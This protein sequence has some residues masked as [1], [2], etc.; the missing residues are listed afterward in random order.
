MQP[1]QHHVNQPAKLAHASI[2]QGAGLLILLTLPCA[3]LLFGWQWDPAH[4]NPTLLHFFYWAS[5]TA[6]AYTA[7]LFCAILIWHL[8]LSPRKSLYLIAIL[9]IITALGLGLKSAL[10]DTLREPRPYV[11]WLEKNNF[12]APDQFYQLPHKSLFVSQQDLSQTAVP[13]WQ[14]QYWSK[15]TAYSF[16][17]G[18]SFFAAQW[19]LIMIALLWR[20]KAY[21]TMTLAMLWALAVLASRLYLGMHWPQDLILSC[22]MAFAL[23]WVGNIFWNKWVIAG[24]SSA[25]PN[26]PAQPADNLINS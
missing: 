4:T 17:S 3:A 1:S 14:Q 19:A 5:Q 12:I 11:I 8:K 25:T 16:P 22:L 10:K 23:V 18:H 13:A 21:I 26:R 9:L 24:P 6:S 7:L 2:I 15:N 20:Q